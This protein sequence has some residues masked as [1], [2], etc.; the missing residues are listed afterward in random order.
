VEQRDEGFLPP[1]PA[2]PEPDLGEG[3]QP[4]QQQPPQQQPPAQPPPGYQPPPVYQPPPAYQPP[5]G[6]QQPPPY[7]PP[8]VYRPPAP[9]YGWTPPPKQPD[10]GPALAGFIVS[11]VSAAL[12]LF[13]AGFGTPLSIPGAIVGMVLSRRGKQKIDAGETLKHKDLAAA[14]WW[15]GLSI[16]VLSVISTIVWVL[17]IV[18]ASNSESFDDNMKHELQDSQTSGGLRVG[19]AAVYLGAR[20]FC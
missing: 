10:N 12:W 16:L 18:L 3:Q 2:G 1:E 11:M 13:S 5:P 19:L 17:V 6:Y 20:L 9:G 7:Q 8:P 15:V 4:P 14:G